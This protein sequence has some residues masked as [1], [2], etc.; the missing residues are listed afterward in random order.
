MSLAGAKELSG[1]G[2][3]SP[4]GKAYGQVMRVRNYLYDRQWLKTHWLGSPVISVGNLTTGGTGKTPTVIKL[5]KM[6]SELGK[7]PGII[8]RGYGSRK[9][10]EADE[11]LMLRRSLPGVPIVANA[12]RIAGGRI[13]LEQSVEVL[14]ADDAFQHRRLGRDLNLCLVDATNPFGGER[15]LPAGRLREPM[16]GLGRSDMVFLTRCDQAE[17]KTIDSLISR[18][19]EYAGPVPI[20][21]CEHRANGY[22]DAAGKAYAIDFLAGKEVFAFAGIGRPESFFETLKSVGVRLT[23]TRVY[24]DHHDFTDKE[25]VELAE[26]AERSGASAILCTLKDLVKIDPKTQVGNL[27]AL[28]VEICLSVEDE[29]RLSRK[30]GEVTSQFS[31]EK[32][33]GI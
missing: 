21:R 23:G 19:R 12:D 1:C 10:L 8:L 4:L 31:R 5:A 13:A 20:L 26:A 7:R 28:S 11:V 6:V 32:I 17:A 9:G 30:I 33:E 16:A 22:V 29:E 3:L 24:R 18:I 15:V 14:I 2:L 27:L 25:I